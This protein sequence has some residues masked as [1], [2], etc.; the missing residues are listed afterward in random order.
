MGGGHGWCLQQAFEEKLDDPDE[1]DEEFGMMMYYVP[2]L[3]YIQDNGSFVFYFEPLYS[4]E[5]DD[6][7]EWAKKIRKER[8]KKHQTSKQ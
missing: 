7:P 4:P 3:P 5:G 1:D 8:Q 6:F 2:D